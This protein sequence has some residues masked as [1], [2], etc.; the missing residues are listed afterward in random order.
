[1]PNISLADFTAKQKVENAAIIEVEQYSAELCERLEAQML[2]YSIRMVKRN[3]EYFGGSREDL[4]D[5]AKE[6]L[7]DLEEN[8][9]EDTFTI[10]SGRKYHKIV[11]N[12]K[13][14]HGSVH[15]FIDKK[16]GDVY[17]PASWNKPAKHV[18]YNL[19]ERES[20]QLMFGQLDWAGGYLY[21]R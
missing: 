19:L 4:S 3:A 5:Y 9:I 15:A 17:K 2:E 21:A 10:S 1:M 20:R 6:R 12:D 14:G 18:R 7:K 13:G 8:G 11:H 16:T